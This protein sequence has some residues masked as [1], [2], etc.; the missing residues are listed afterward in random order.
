[1]NNLLFLII[2]LII[3][4]FFSKN[5]SQ[6]EEMVKGKWDGICAVCHEE[7]LVSEAMATGQKTNDHEASVITIIK[8]HKKCLLPIAKETL[9]YRED[10]RNYN[11]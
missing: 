9:E 8:G 11:K 3:G 5:T 7:T 10:L 6:T 1:M 2:G 4:A